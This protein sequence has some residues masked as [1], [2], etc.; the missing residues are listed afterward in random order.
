MNIHGIIFD[1]D[2]TILDITETFYHFILWKASLIGIQLPNR[3]T[4]I[5][6]LYNEHFWIELSGGN[7]TFRSIVNE[8]FYEIPREFL[9]YSK[10]YPGLKNSLQ[11]LYDSGVKMILTSSW[12]AT[13]KTKGILKKHEMLDYFTYVFTAD[14]VSKITNI[15]QTKLEL[16][17]KSFSI[18]GTNPD[19]TVVVGDTY[20]DVRVGKELGVKTIG[21][22]TGS[23]LFRKK[24]QNLKPDLIIDSAANLPEVLNPLSEKQ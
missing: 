4:I 5:K 16:M 14:D 24:F 9:Q 19:K 21:V 15:Y 12:S 23:S 11:I 22:L 10:P 20:Q 2:G 18:L 3:E 13:E 6:N 1:R 8:H 17:S 7:F